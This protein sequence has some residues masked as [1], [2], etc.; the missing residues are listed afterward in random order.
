M[1]SVLLSLFLRLR[2]VLLELA[3]AG[4]IVYGVSM[5]STAA[6]V[7]VAGVFVLAKSMEL[8]LRGDGP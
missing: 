5:L 7:I 3:G 8:D 6:A 2:V 1:V 4:V